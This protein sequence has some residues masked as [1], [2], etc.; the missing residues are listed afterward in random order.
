MSDPFDVLSGVSHGSHL[1]PVAAKCNTL[2]H[3]VTERRAI[4]LIKRGTSFRI[5][6]LVSIKSRG[7]KFYQF[8]RKNL[9][10]TILPSS[11]F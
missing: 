1:A 7:D 9:R 10:D 2:S 11:V 3:R 4:R 6:F 8:V 5:P